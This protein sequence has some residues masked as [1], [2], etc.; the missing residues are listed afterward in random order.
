VS[1]TV[2]TPA[3]TRRRR[4][5]VFLDGANGRT[6]SALAAAAVLLETLRAPATDADA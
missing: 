5:L 3:G 1:V 4:R 6:R 2:V